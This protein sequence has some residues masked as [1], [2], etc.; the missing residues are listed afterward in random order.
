MYYK[1]KMDKLKDNKFIA[2]GQQ[3]QN[4]HC[5]CSKLYLGCDVSRAKWGVCGSSPS[6][7][8]IYLQVHQQTNEKC[9]FITKYYNVHVDNICFLVTKNP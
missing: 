4:T 7:K 3:F 8:Y 9:K 6:L 5:I 1:R 2:K